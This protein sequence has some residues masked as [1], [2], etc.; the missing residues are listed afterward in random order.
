MSTGAGG[1]D[2]GMETPVRVY[3]GSQEAQMLPVK[4]LEYSIRKHT[5]L[6]VEILPLHHAR[7]EFPM[8]RDVRNRPRTPFSFQRFQIPK[9]AG[10]RGRGIYL[11]SDMQVFKDIG[12]L[13]GMPFDGADLLSAWEPGDGGRRP[14]FSVMLLNCDSLRW[15]LPEIVRGLDQG[16]LTYE[17]LMYEMRVAQNIRASIDPSW[18]SLEAYE[19]GRTA[20][21]HYTDMTRQPWVS[22]DNPLGYLWVRD[23]LEAIERGFIGRELVEA[24]VREGHLRPSLLYQVDY[25]IEDTRKLPA[26]AVAL[27][28][29]FVP[30]Y[31]LMEAHAGA[32]RPGLVQRARGL[33][34]R[35]YERSPFFRGGRRLHKARS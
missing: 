28:R 21:L 7:V 16:E 25:R 32:R 31:K 3:V 10:F 35:V 11:D 6:P 14:Q 17:T 30:P 34:R 29:E 4:V 33:L 22:R 24:H 20:L 15:E 26:G 1:G 12:G 5:E 8:P 18:N 23:L 19:G 13:W 9:L 27:D 2:R